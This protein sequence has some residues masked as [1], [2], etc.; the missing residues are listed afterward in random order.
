L[1]TEASLS[2]RAV[3]LLG[4]AES[5]PLAATTTVLAGVVMRA[6]FIIDGM[7]W[8]TATVSGMDAS[9]AVLALVRRLAREDLGGVL[10]HGSVIAGYNV[11]D[12]KR[13]HD[14]TRLPIISVSQEPQSDLRAILQDK[15]PGDWQKRWRTLE[16]NS[17]PYSLLL[18]TGNTVF[19]QCHGAQATTAGRLVK[20]LT[21][22]GGMPEPLRV[23]RLLAR[24]VKPLRSGRNSEGSEPD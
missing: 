3:R 10:L 15:F 18:P 13:V 24:A 8:V 9:D 12:L 16:Q 21:R 20:R 6:D 5:S 1:G 23:A 22:F 7:A 4:V 2:K 14:A 11:I 19:L 17:S